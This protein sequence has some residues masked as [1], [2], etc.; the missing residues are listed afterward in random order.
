MIKVYHKSHSTILCIIFFIKL[1]TKIFKMIY[2]FCKVFSAKLFIFI[3]ILYFL[4]KDIVVYDLFVY[5]NIISVTIY[6][7][8]VFIE[9]AHP[10]YL[11]VYL[12][13][14][15]FNQSSFYN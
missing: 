11:M 5:K 10:G 14:H 8:S 15:I 12:L 3:F 7:N 13:K 6:K 9:G 2:F 1:V 4:Q